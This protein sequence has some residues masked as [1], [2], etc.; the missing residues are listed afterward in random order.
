[1]LTAVQYIKGYERLEPGVMKVA[2][3]VFR[4]GKA[5]NCSYLFGVGCA[6][7]MFD[8]INPVIPFEKKDQ[9]NL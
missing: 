8:Y 7:A 5:S 1:M 4:R 9:L 2:S 3:P 6:V